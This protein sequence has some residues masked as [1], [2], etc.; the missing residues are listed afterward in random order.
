MIK[1]DLG[2]GMYKK[3]GYIGIDIKQYEGVDYIADIQNRI[4]FAD[5]SVS[6]I[7][8]KE[9]LEH[10]EHPINALEEMYRVLNKNGEIILS[11]PNIMN[12]RRFLRWMIKGKS[13]VAKEHIE[14]WGL[15]ELI[16]LAERAKL[17][18]VCH[19]T[20]TLPR[21]HKLNIIEKIVKRI[22]PNIG[23]K[24]LVVVFKKC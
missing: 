8:C 7:N 6:M 11:V 1:I 5:N 21:Y 15:P 23:D 2:C 3:E 12:F 19:Y 10:L 22:N 13:T 18:Y 9:V 14:S 24:N 20:E 16:N 17:L 4:P